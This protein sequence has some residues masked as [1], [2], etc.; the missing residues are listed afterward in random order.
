MPAH[1]ATSGS[2][3]TN[4]VAVLL[5]LPFEHEYDYRV[6]AGMSVPP[7]TF[8]TVP[9]GRR[10][11]TGVVW[12]EARGEIE[13][14]R[15]KDIDAA[16]DSPAMTEALRNLVD[17]VA[18][19]TLAKRGS[20]LRMA[21]SVPAALDPPPTRIAYRIGGEP[22]AR[23][24]VA[25]ERVLA[26]LGDGLP[27]TASEI[28][29]E[30]G[31]G[32]GVVQGLVKSET[33]AATRLPVEGTFAAPDWRRA[34]PTLSSEQT[35]AAEALSARVLDDAFSVNLLDG[36]T[37]SGKTE[38]YFEAIAT[39][40]EAGRQALVML[41]EIALGAQW[42]R[43]FRERF[44]TEP[45][46]WHSE[47]GARARRETWRAVARGH[48]SVVVG[49]RSALWL[50]Y[51]RLGLIVVDEEHDQAFKQEDGVIYHARDMAVV[52]ARLEQC[53]I[54]LSSATPALESVEN[55]REGRYQ[56]LRLPD[57]HGGATLPEIAAVDL[58][59]TPPP[60]GGW[61]SPPLRTG[62]QDALAAGEQA[63]LFLN[64]RG[65]APLT[66]CRKCGHRLECPNCS[67][68]LVEHRFAGTLNCHHCGHHIKLP[69][70]CPSCDAEEALAACGPGVERIA[71]EI[72][73]LF[74]GARAEIVTSDTVYG[75]QAA[76]ALIH[77][78][79]AQEIDIL[80]GT[81]MIAKGHD[82]PMLTLV[83][84]VDAD[85]GLAGGDLRAAERTYQ[86]LQQVAGRAG[87]AER[88][89]RVLLQT[90]MPEHPVMEALVSGDR[91]AFLAR[92]ADA[93]RDYGQP[94]FGRLAGLIL[95]GPNDAAVARTAAQ[96]ARIARQNADSEIEVF[97]PAPAAMSLLRG[98]YRHRLLIKAPRGT[99]LQP[100]IR[101]WMSRIDPPTGVRL[102][103]DIDPYSFH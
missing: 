91:E 48:A 13:A 24:T 102:Q 99:R 68:W 88:P 57:R 34:G 103:V 52:R 51:P 95:S 50:P 47:L 77:R 62:L 64:R 83:G 29:H 37:G 27:R 16:L 22:P 73:V 82:F 45:A 2:A 10:A 42:L 14:E 36:V 20:V 6:P 67:A 7:G 23:M 56:R 76:E 11:A 17:W 44:G 54:A 90:Y 87:R 3:E 100:H 1:D 35:I 12:G 72:Q 41:P 4:R 70:T 63:M 86:L 38:V 85:L 28:A 69:E 98:R 15:L 31:A 58:R 96:L 21:M 30:S 5:P 75:P 61:L 43:R 97:G 89:G 93:R 94:P 40:L 39:A 92:E 8:V 46:V 84:V 59:V 81:Q 74:P 60:R 26:L 80:I 18:A 101:A 78:I 33:L 65:Y 32:T 53:P 9:F 55:V 79:V 71:E 25:R 66:L 49:A 19:Y